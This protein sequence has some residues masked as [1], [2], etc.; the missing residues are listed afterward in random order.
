MNDAQCRNPAIQ[1]RETTAG[2]SE[3]R[4]QIRNTFNLEAN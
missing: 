3:S 1:A 2:Q 4:L